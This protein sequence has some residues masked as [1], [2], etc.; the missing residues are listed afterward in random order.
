MTPGK[1]LG[2]AILEAKIDLAQNSGFE[3][4]I[5]G[6]TLLGDPALILVP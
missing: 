4:V 6:M 5:L 1:T 3:D 2:E